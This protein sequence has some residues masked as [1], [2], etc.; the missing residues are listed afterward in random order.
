MAAGAA[1]NSSLCFP[2]IS[3]GS[4]LL[5]LLLLP[6]LF[7]PPS[8]S[9]LFLPLPSLCI[10]AALNMATKNAALELKRSGVW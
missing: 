3:L 6:L 9:S 10:Q 5:L 2:F 7:L 8:P 1:R 4:L